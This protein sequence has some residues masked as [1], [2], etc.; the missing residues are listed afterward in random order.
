MVLYRCA[1]QEA[2]MILR[3]FGKTGWKVSAVG[4][5]TWNLANQWGEMD[6]ETATDIVRTAHANGINLIDT[7]ESYGIP[8]GLSEIRVGKALKGMRDKVYLVSKIGHWGKR[9]GQ[10]IPKTTEDMIRGCGHACCGRLRTDWID[11]MLCHEADIEDPGIYIEGFEA[12][13]K[14]GFIREYGISTDSVEVL[15]KFNDMSDGACAVVELNYS[16]INKA[17]EKELLPY[18][19]KHRIAVLARGPVAMGLL[20]GKYNA[21]SVFTDTVRS[22]WNKGEEGRSDFEER[23]KKAEKVREITGSDEM[24]TTAVRYVISHPHQPV[25]IPGATTPDQARRNAHAGEQVLPSDTY[26]KLRQID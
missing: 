11:V 24:A 15:T 21:E 18:C 6:D 22:G 17:P 12:L 23:M 2:L 5:G 26:D 13:K 25:A 14:E 16:L 9:T 4:L 1:K 10:G 8:N 19:E 3:D 20:G 7:A